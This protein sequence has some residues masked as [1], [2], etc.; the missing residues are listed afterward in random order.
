MT[1]ID[2]LRGRLQRKLLA[3]RT[4]SLTNERF[5]GGTQPLAFMD[6]DELQATGGRIKALNVNLARLAVDELA[7]RLQVT[8]LRSSPGDVVDNDLW[9]LWRSV[10]LDETSQL[11]QLDALVHGRGFFMAW[12]DAA[13]ELSI[14]AE[15][16][17]ALAVEWDPVTRR[18]TAAYKR[19]STPD[20]YGHGLL[21]TPDR[22]VE[23]VTVSPSTDTEWATSTALITDDSTKVVRD[24][25]NPVGQVPV[26]PLVNRPR[27]NLLDGESEIADLR[28]PVQAIS[29]LC[30]D[31]LVASDYAAAPKR[32]ATGLVPLAT[33]LTPQQL[34]EVTEAVRAKWEQ[35]RKQKFTTSTFEGTKFGTF[36]QAE[37]S[38]FDVAVKLLTNQVA[39]LSGLPAYFVDNGAVNP[40]SA[41]A[42]RVSESRLTARALQRQRWWSGSYEDLIRLA[43]TI[44]DGRPDPRLDDLETVW[45]DPEPS[46]DAQ[47]AD[48]VSKTYASGIVDRRAALEALD[49]SPLEIER[50][51]AALEPK[52]EGVIA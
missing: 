35:V 51:L 26:V 6:P 16:P 4:E 13:G 45:L 34:D 47:T 43:V 33:D 14:T 9:A 25:E 5:Y 11:A 3:Q 19:W 10:G 38:N 20:G 32:W 1:T 39:T 7:T 21:L 50:I 42:M 8:G 46:T 12:V 18:V 37:L 52:P 2:D 15:S 17:T 28:G 31:L 48:A 40:V 27:T 23:Y 22:I 41:E 49:L 44:R 30:T 36:D 29:K 24:E